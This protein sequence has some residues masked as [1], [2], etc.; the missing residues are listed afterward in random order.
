M[1]RVKA[2]IIF[3]SYS[4]NTAELARLLKNELVLKNYEVELENIQ[5]KEA[6]S[7][8]G[9]D[10]VLIGTCTRKEGQLPLLWSNYFKNGMYEHKNVAI[11]GTGDSRWQFYCG[12]CDILSD[13]YESKHSILRIEQFPTDYHMVKIVEWIHEITK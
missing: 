12:A 5:D 4:G 6:T 13:W 10:L 7:L 9:Y 11:F 8:A 2:K 1:N 3:A